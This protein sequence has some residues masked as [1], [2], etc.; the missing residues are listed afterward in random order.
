MR[1]ITTLSAKSQ[2]RHSIFA[3]TKFYSTKLRGNE[4]GDTKKGMESNFEFPHKKLPVISESN[5]SDLRDVFSRS[6]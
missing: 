3:T 6:V 5:I 2:K 4:W 1:E